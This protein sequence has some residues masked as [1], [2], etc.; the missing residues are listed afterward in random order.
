MVLAYPDHFISA[1]FHAITQQLVED[2]KKQGDK[3]I[4]HLHYANHQL[5]LAHHDQTHEIDINALRLACSCALC[6]S[7]AGLAIQ[8]DAVPVDIQPVGQYAIGVQWSDNHASLY[9]H[10]ALVELAYA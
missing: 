9:P 8:E 6:T 1:A 3:K 7:K 5:T 4:P 10:A 2:L